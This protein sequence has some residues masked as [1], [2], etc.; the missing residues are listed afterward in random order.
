M[1][2]YGDQPWHKLGQRLD[3]PATAVEAISASGLDY[4]VGKSKINFFDGNEMGRVFE[5]KVVT[6]RKD[7]GD[8]LGIVG[9][10][11]KIVQNAEAFNFFDVLVGEGQAIYHTAGALGR[12]ERVWILAKLPNDIIVNGSDKVEK[13]LVLT[14]SHDGLSTLKV[15][16]TPIRVVCQNTLTASLRDAKSG[17]SIRHS[18][19]I[20][21]KIEEARKVL[22]ISVNYYDQFEKIIK[23]FGSKKI[24]KDDAVLYFESVMAEFSKGDGIEFSKQQEKKIE[25]CQNL[26][27]NGM[28]NDN[29]DV[30]GTLWTAYNAVTE[31]CDYH[32]GI[33]G[34]DGGSGR[35]NDALFGTGAGIKAVA[36]EKAVQLIG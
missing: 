9:E 8:Q 12:G 25:I 33:K 23:G 30:K 35:V 1:F 29:P 21:G 24:S 32:R 31:F 27:V 20:N 26:F 22:N 15:Y 14:N 34:V 6:Y 13:Y 11:Y 16:F 7:T 28:G 10:G 3:N 4:E 19:N 5:G 17:I 2:Y 36:F 18:G